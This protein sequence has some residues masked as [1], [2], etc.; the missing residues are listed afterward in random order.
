MA[1]TTASKTRTRQS[2]GK[3]KPTTKTVAVPRP[4]LKSAEENEL[5]EV[6]IGA[7]RFSSR[8]ANED[9]PYSEREVVFYLDDKEWTAPV[10]VPASWGLHFLR[11]KLGYGP[12]MAVVYA[13]EQALT[14]DGVTA[15]ESIPNLDVEILDG[16]TKKITQKFLDVLNN[17]K[18]GSTNGSKS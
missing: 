8:P 7:P 5:I 11:L 15:L 1:A 10:K 2:A 9:N 6:P 16:I 4:L 14:P 13:M 12:D 18:D 3:P 17:P